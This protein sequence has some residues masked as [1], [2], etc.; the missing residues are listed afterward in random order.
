M[1]TGT[2]VRIVCVVR[3][4]VRIVGCVVCVVWCVVCIV[5]SVIQI[6]V[7]ASVSI[8]FLERVVVVVGLWAVGLVDGVVREFRAVVTLGR[9]WWKNP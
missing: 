2:C 6:V 4:V 5:G 9:R 1:T 7:V 8:A 3:C